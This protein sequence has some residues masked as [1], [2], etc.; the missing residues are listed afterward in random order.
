MSCE[1]SRNVVVAKV[2]EG[3]PTIMYVIR[4][5]L[6]IILCTPV[7]PGRSNHMSGYLTTQAAVHKYIDASFLS[8][9]FDQPRGAGRG[10]ARFL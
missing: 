7:M 3:V 2:G 8:S 4:P 6:T 5:S 1:K 10:S 9:L